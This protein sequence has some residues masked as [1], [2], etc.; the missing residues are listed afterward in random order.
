M[1]ANQDM[2]TLTINEFE[3]LVQPVDAHEDQGKVLIDKLR[4]RTTGLVAQGSGSRTE[5]V[6]HFHTDG[7]HNYSTDKEL[8][9]LLSPQ[10][11]SQLEG[12]HMESGYEECLQN[13]GLITDYDKYWHQ[14]WHHFLKAIHD[15]HLIAKYKPQFVSFGGPVADIM[16]TRF[17]NAFNWMVTAVRVKGII[18]LLKTGNRRPIV[19]E[20]N[21][22]TYCALNFLHSI[23]DRDDNRKNEYEKHF[24]IN[25]LDVD[26][27]RL[28]TLNEVKAV[29][30]KHQEVDLKLVRAIRSARNHNFMSKKLLKFWSKAWVQGMDQ[31]VM[32]NIEDDN[33]ILDVEVRYVSQM[34]EQTHGKWS[35]DRCIEF[36]NRFLSFAKTCITED[37]V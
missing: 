23:T 28:L 3:S 16:A 36:L 10:K 37:R 2:T 33:H 8:P 29:D 14:K 32:A 27:H 4:V 11:W 7:Q 12:R 1:A 6:F 18:Y 24:A 30:D 9:K 21:A 17:D 13:D 31:I 26:S 34:P 22:W 25:C 20:P 19:L 5:R 35:D 15:N